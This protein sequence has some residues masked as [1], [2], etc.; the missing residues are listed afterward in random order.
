M[1]HRDLR[2]I[3]SLPVKSDESWELGVVPMAEVVGA[4]PSGDQFGKDLMLVLWRSSST[5]M[6]HTRPMMLCDGET[7]LDEVL[8]SALEFHHLHD[9]PFRP[10]SI[11]CN[12][13]DLVRGL[14][15]V[16]GQT[17]PSV[18]YVS[19]YLT[20]KRGTQCWRI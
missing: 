16:V 9:F 10:A 4:K 3:L 13:E 15:K 20:C 8:E 18:D 6:V 5:E 19:E 11:R 12:D 2:P 7:A 1:R 14:S 17:G